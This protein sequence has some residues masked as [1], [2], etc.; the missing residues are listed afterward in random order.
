[1]TNVIL[2]HHALGVTEGVKAFAE[3]I[4]EGGHNVT[5]GDLFEGRTFDNIE[6]GVAHEE[7]IGWE[8]MIARSEAAIADLPAE[9]VVA[10]FS[11]GTVYGQ[12]LVQTRPGALGALLYH[13]GDNPPGEFEVPWPAGAG[14]QVHVS[15]NDP[16]F[17]LEGGQQLVAETGGSFFSTRALRTCSRTARGASTTGRR[18]TSSSSARSP[19][20][21]APAERSDPDLG[22]DVQDEEGRGDGEHP[23]RDH[24]AA[25]TSRST[26]SPA[27]PV[28]KSSPDSLSPNELSVRPVCSRTAADALGSEASKPQ[29]VPEQ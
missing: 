22:V 16:W 18:P 21:I 10:G 8:P 26:L 3:R 27:I 24:A 17:N 14:L 19:S 2:F 5:V 28:A 23:V 29:I 20:S 7:S 4:R 25:P 15:E 12:R 6:E 11:L 13:G 1:M 9:V